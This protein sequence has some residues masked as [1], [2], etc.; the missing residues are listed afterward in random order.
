MHFSTVIFDVGKFQLLFFLL[1]LLIKVLDAWL[2]KFV[3]KVSLKMRRIKNQVIF[4]GCGASVGCTSGYSVGHFACLGYTLYY[5]SSRVLLLPPVYVSRVLLLP[6]VHVSVPESASV[7][8]FTPEP[9][10]V[11]ESTPETAPVHECTLEPT[12][13]HE[14][15][16]E[17]TQA[18]KLFLCY[19]QPVSFLPVLS[20]SQ[21]SLLSFLPVLFWLQW[22]VNHL[23]AL[24]WPKRLSLNFQNVLLKQRRQF[25]S[26]LPVLSRPWRLSLNSE[27]FLTR[28][29]KLFLN[30]LP[31]LLQPR[32]PPLNIL[33]CLN[34]S[35]WEAKVEKEERSKVHS[36]CSRACSRG[37][38]SRAC[39]IQCN[40]QNLQP[41]RV[42][43]QS[44]QP[45]RMPCQ[46]FQASWMLHMKLIG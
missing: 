33:T 42:P 37:S 10:P 14:S 19:C 27:L 39:Y 7:H 8:E 15:A 38:S 25:L 32:R 34:F 20:Q 44:L 21:K 35:H 5:C 26:L 3:Y 43:R 4:S 29:R 18:P 23:T 6:P 40:V 30:T 22:P 41:S 31:I 45:S 11:Y 24:W 9:A 36:G 16:P 17:P 12:P 13:V 1:V 2:D 46:C 28:P